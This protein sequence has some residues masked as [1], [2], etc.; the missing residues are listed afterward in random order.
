MRRRAGLSESAHPA[1]ALI[2]PL[3]TNG[4]K[5]P[6]VRPQQP[7]GSG[8]PQPAAAPRILAL[9]QACRQAGLL[10]RAKGRPPVGCQDAWG[11][12]RKGRIPNGC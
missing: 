2:H 10:G 7:V 9:T 5:L 1:A 11:Q 12:G 6:K 4:E 8:C 3:L